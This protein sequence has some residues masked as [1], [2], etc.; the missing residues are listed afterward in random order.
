M[1]GA[2]CDR[3]LVH[4]SCRVGHG[5]GERATSTVHPEG[6]GGRQAGASASAWSPSSRSPAAHRAR[7]GVGRSVGRR[8]SRRRGR[9]QP[10][11]GAAASVAASASAAASAA[12]SAAASASGAADLSPVHRQAGQGALRWQAVDDRLRLVL[13]HR[14]VRGRSQAGP[15][16]ARSRPRM[17]DDQ[18]AGRQHR[19]RDGRPERQGPRPAEGRRGDPLQRDPGRQPGPVPGAQGRQHPA[20]VAAPCRSTA[21]RSSRTTTPPT[22]CRPARRSARRSRHPASRPGSRSSDASTTRIRPSSAWT[23]SSR[24]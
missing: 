14:V 3:V 23:A 21:T 8:P 24:G 15:R 7:A 11:A 17:R 20:R 6:P 9:S 19:P 16:E 4:R 18:G 10:G 1:T 13:G 2:V 5:G 12:G 22:A